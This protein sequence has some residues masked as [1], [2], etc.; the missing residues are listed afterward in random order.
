MSHFVVDLMIDL[1]TELIQVVSGLWPATS[2]SSLLLIVDSDA[3]AIEL[4]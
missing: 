1:M 3:G 4:C 2:H